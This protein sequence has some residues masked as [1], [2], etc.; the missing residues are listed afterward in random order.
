MLGAIG[1]TLN[2][3][4]NALGDAVD[5][6]DLDVDTLVGLGMGIATGN[7]MQIGFYA[8]DVLDGDQ[9]TLVQQFDAF[10]PLANLAMGGPAAAA[11]GV[12]T[13]EDTGMLAGVLAGPA[14]AG[15]DADA[16]EGNE[17]LANLLRSLAAIDAR[18]T[19]HI[20]V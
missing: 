18:G 13:G 8:M 3:A 20:A 2:S 12:L 10:M 1:N 15:A 9:D 7:P 17:V 6:L 14:T 19:T 16:L 11:A 4:M 5:K